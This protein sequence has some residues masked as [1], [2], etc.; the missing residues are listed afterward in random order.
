V[1]GEAWSEFATAAASPA[2]LW[3]DGNETFGW[4]RHGAGQ[5]CEVPISGAPETHDCK[6]VLIV[7]SRSFPAGNLSIMWNDER[8]RGLDLDPDGRPHRAPDG[9]PVPPPHWQ[10]YTDEGVY[11]VE[12]VDLA[13]HG[14]RGPRDA[15][16]WF[17]AKCAITWVL[18]Q[19]RDPPVQGALRLRA[20]VRQP[21]P[22][23]R[24]SNRRQ[25]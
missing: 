22:P 15:T 24:R 4:G 5:R 23:R 3:I 17:L 25:R 13:A 14:I 19:W 16:R 18:S 20:R 10:W 8:V 12:A 1:S 21:N 7:P 6:L 11:D 9:R 2:G